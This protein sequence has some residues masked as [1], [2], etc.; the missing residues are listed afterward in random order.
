MIRLNPYGGTRIDGGRRV[1]ADTEGSFQQEAPFSA[2]YVLMLR[3]R[4]RFPRLHHHPANPLWITEMSA[5][6]R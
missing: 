2:R 3:S 5:H 1:A 4:G 6:E